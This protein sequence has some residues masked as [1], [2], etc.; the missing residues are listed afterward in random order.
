MLPQLKLYD[1]EGNLAGVFPEPQK[2]VDATV[3]D[4]AVRACLTKKTP[5]DSAD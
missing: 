1:R 4:A 5:E 2:P 3:L